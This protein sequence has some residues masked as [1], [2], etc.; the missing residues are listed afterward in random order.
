MYFVGLTSAMDVTAA[1]ERGLWDW[2]LMTHQDG[3]PARSAHAICIAAHTAKA[4]IHR[5]AGALLVCASSTRDL[6]FRLARIDFC[7]G[8]C[9]AT[10]APFPFMCGALPF[11][12]MQET[13]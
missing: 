12:C 7:S 8:A 13:I 3:G 10:A 11:A 4:T 6:R 1:F 2:R 5:H 9:D